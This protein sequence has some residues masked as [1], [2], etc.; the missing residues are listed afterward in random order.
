MHGETMHGDARHGSKTQ[1]DM[2]PAAP[3][4]LLSLSCIAVRDETPSVKTFRLRSDGG[5]VAFLPGQALTLRV[6]L[7]AGPA[8]RSFTISGGPG[9]DLELTVKAQAPAGATRWLHDN[10]VAGSRIEARAPRGGFTLGLRRTDRLAFVSGGSGATPMMAMLRHL[11]EFEPQIDL[12]WFHAARDPDE[13]LFAGELAALQARMPN[14]GVAISVSRPMPGWF[15]YRGRISRARLVAAVPDLGR[16]ELFCCGPQGFMREAR[17]IHAAEGGVPDHFHTESF[18]GMPVAAPPP[19]RDS[20]TRDGDARNGDVAF[21]LT[22]NGRAI[23]IR[24]GETLLQA[25][26]RQGLVIPCGCGEGMCGTC[27]VRLV[28]GRVDSRPQGGLTPEEAAEGYVL[29]CSTR[30]MSDV[31]IRLP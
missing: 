27:M 1:M 31:E 21:G 19:G 29:A 20:D 12:A 8:W 15:G 16:R 5:P 30:A 4:A 18:G 28:S 11:A 17:L 6:P 7:P 14:L 13:V 23:G 26:L 3:S 10:L 22:V 9:G 2:Q 25:G 24:D